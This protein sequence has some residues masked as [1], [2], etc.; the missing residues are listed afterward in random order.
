MPW[1]RSASRALEIARA[2][3]VDAPADTKVTFFCRCRV[4]LESGEEIDAVLAVT[5]TRLVLSHPEHAAAWFRRRVHVSDF[6]TEPE[7]R[8]HQLRLEVPGDVLTVET[9]SV[10]DSAR[11]MRLL[12]PRAT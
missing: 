7:R 12:A 2:A 6:R 5:R 3:G 4:R 11:L 9:E 8:R 10:E 1:R